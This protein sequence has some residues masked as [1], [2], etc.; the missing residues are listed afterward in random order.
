MERFTIGPAGLLSAAESA[1]VDGFPSGIA[2]DP[3]GN[4]LGWP[5]G[6]E[7]L[8]PIAGLIELDVQTWC[9]REMVLDALV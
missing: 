3:S 9:H 7:T 1:S 6:G 2:F 5:L 4:T 8:N